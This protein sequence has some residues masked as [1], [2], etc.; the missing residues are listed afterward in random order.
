[1]G[2]KEYLVFAGVTGA[3]LL[4]IRELAE[5]GY[6]SGYLDYF[7]GN[8]S[9]LLNSTGRNESINNSIISTSLPIIAHAFALGGL[10]A[11]VSKLASRQKPAF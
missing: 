2:T 6:M 3:A 11:L 1:M 10:G 8:I 9:N 5:Q 7:A 4:G